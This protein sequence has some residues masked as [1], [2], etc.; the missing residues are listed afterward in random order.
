MFIF[1]GRPTD[2]VRTTLQSKPSWLV[3]CLGPLTCLFLHWLSFSIINN[4]VASRL[5]SAIPSHGPMLSAHKQWLFV[6]GFLGSVIY[7]ILPFFALVLIIC[8]DVLL[9]DSEN[10]INLLKTTC[11]SFYSLFPYLGIVFCLSLTFVPPHPI[12]QGNLS[13]QEV[14]EIARDYRTTVQ[15]TPTMSL[16]HVGGILAYLCISL[17]LTVGYRAFSHCSL[18]FAFIL[19]IG[20]GGFLLLL[21]S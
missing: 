5:I 11:L 1:S 6:A 18:R 12:V 15:L 21:V 9:R 8:V 17:L 4:K 16:I 20:V 14:L 3:L 2:A 7:T 13:A 19:G 10:Y